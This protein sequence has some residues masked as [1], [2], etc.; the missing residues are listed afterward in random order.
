MNT[1]TQAQF[2]SLGVQVAVSED[3]TT[4][5]FTVMAENWPIVRAFLALETQWRITAGPGGVIWSGL[6]YAAAEARLGRRRFRRVASHLKR[7][8]EAALPSLNQS[9]AP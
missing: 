4:E 1:G 6:D 8:E 5:C 9:D 3:D 2:A 7:M